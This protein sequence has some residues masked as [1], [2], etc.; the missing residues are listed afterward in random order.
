MRHSRRRSGLARSRRCAR[1]GCSARAI[2]TRRPRPIRA[3]DTRPRSLRARS[4][5]MHVLGPLLRVVVPAR[6][7]AQRRARSCSP[8]AGAGDRM[9]DGYAVRDGDQRLR[10]GAHDV[11][12]RQPQDVH[13][14]G[15]VEGAQN[16]VNVECVRVRVD[17]EPL[18][19]LNLE[20]LSSPHGL[21]RLF[22]GGLIL[23]C[24]RAGHSVAWVRAGR[25]QPPS[26]RPEWRARRRMRSNRRPASRVRHVELAGRHPGVHHGVGDERDGAL[27][28]VHRLP[29]R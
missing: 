20:Y 25:S 21:E 12:A 15:R 10:A 13:V 22:D 23:P 6:R 16:P 14:R 9:Q 17:L 2:R 24:R 11:E 18:T 19:N 28:V 7:P 1:H 4:T 27:M 3:R 5:S 29:G 8:P 26:A